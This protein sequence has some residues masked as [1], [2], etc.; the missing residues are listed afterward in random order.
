M[1]IAQINATC[2]AGSTGKIAVDISA[3]STA[4]DIENR[5]FYSSGKSEY[6]LGDKYMNAVQTKFFALKSRIAGN[7]GFNSDTPTKDLIGRLEAYSPD[8][9][10]IHNIHGHNCNLS[11][12]FEYLQSSAFRVIWTF[13]DCW[14]FTGYCM[15]YYMQKCD[16]WKS[17]CGEC[18]QRASYSWFL[19]RSKFLYNSKRALFNAF[20][21]TIVVPSAWLEKEVKQSFLRNHSVRVIRN[22]IDL[23]VFAPSNSNIKKTYGLEQNIVVLGVAFGWTERKGLDVFIE[24]AKRLPDNYRIVLVGTDGKADQMLP[25]NIISIHRTHNQQELAE[26]YAAADVFVNPTREDT[27][28]TVNMESL[29][30]G[31]PVITF[32]TG[33][34]PEIIT[35]EC[36]SVI[37]RDDIDALE[38]EIIRVCEARP[39]SAEACLARAKA[40]DKQ[41]RVQEYIDLYK[42]V[43]NDRTTTN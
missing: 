2:G 42:E 17:G 39:Y 19:D 16:K 20:D 3:M 8:I 14:A 1:K 34:S 6:T 30:C 36:G 38:M 31:T 9:I 24:L 43:L 37:A 7:W 12:F 32:D 33:G 21:F 22:G 35:D 28:P 11:L 29:A 27:Y 25:K 4:H 5:I 40:F 23:S 10:H 26:I 18:P 15:H 41:D 13:H